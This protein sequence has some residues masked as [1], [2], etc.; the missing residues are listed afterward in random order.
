MTRVPVLIG[1]GIS[2]FGAVAGDIPLKHIATRQYA[3]GLVQSE[4]ELG[5]QRFVTISAITKKAALAMPDPT[6]RS[7][8]DP[9]Q[10]SIPVSLPSARAALSALFARNYRVRL[11]SV[12]DNYNALAI[13]FGPG[14]KASEAIFSIA[15]FPNAGSVFFCKARSCPI[16]TRF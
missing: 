13:G 4:Y 12:Y 15:V 14:E 5:T 1:E 11:K 8:C 2:L 10:N 9:S 7:S 6:P 16:P 3:S